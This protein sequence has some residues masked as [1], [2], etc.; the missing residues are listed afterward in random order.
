MRFA[1]LSVL[2]LAGGLLACG[3]S[4]RASSVGA[5]SPGTAAPVRAQIVATDDDPG[6][7]AAEVFERARL[8]MNVGQH[9][10][11]RVLFDR[12]V[13]AERAERPGGES[14][15]ARAAAYNAAL[16]SETLDEPRDARDRFR[17]LAKEFPGNADTTDA[18]LRRARL[19]VELEDWT[20]LGVA[21]SALLGVGALARF[22]RVEALAL[23]ALSQI[24]GGHDLVA[25]DKSMVRATKLFEGKD[26]PDETPPPQN[27]AALQ[28]ARGDL[29]RA[30]GDAIAFLDS[31][32]PKAPIVSADFPARLETR[33]Q[34]ILDAQD[35]YVEAI[36]THQ[37]RWA[38][39]AGV[40]VATMYLDLHRD[41]MGIPPP[42]SAT[43]DAKKQL[44][45]GAMRLRYRI[46]LEKGLGTLERTLNLETKAGA[47]S[48]WLDHARKA[49]AAVEKQ[50][51]DEKAA[52]A[53]LPYSEEELKKALEL[54][55][56]KPA[57]T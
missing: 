35:A 17:A 54:L 24:H 48:V 11:A 34:K 13:R 45:T 18:E 5:R 3:P 47:K 23:Q 53:K 40:R 33:C 1:L 56:K 14:G 9:A 22:D 41:V 43:D 27:A 30:Q 38:V 19:D 8:A 46:L 42:K 55:A 10:H 29:L 51:A 2:L 12:V 7:T 15:L 21:S 28:F 50:L 36:N 25:A 31:K 4:S 6:G 39:R 49:K 52:L 20:D 32:D 26:L 44:F 16:C 57:K 37:L